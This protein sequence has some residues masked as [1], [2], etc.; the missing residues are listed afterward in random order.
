MSAWIFS[1]WIDMPVCDPPFGKSTHSVHAGRMH[2]CPNTVEPAANTV[3]AAI[4]ASTITPRI[5][6]LLFNATR[7]KK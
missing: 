7:A 1:F 6:V 5:H 3:A 4:A 2:S